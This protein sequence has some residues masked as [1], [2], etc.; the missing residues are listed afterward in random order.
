MGMFPL[1][2]EL[3]GVKELNLGSRKTQALHN[4]L[5][6][7]KNLESCE[8]DVDYAVSQKHDTT[9]A[10]SIAIT[11]LVESSETLKH[12]RVFGLSRDEH[13]QPSADYRLFKSLKILTLDCASVM[14]SCFAIKNCLPISLEILGFDHYS[15]YWDR[16]QPE[17]EK[18]DYMLARLITKEY[19]PNLKTL[20]VPEFPVNRYYHRNVHASYNS[21]WE[22]GRAALKSIQS[23][24]SGKIG[25][26]LL[27]PREIREFEA[28]TDCS[29]TIY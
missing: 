17:Y 1:R 15:S 25:L 24:K 28:L 27:K 29:Q 26:H 5:R 10:S 18:E 20:A 6:V 3:G 12:L 9:E 22:K 23:I 4:L 8:I 14:V 7:T 16:N 13:D 19:V 11:G 2:K 21:A